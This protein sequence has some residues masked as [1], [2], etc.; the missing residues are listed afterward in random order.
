[1]KNL[2]AIEGADGAGKSTQVTLL[3]T[4]LIRRGYTV[5]TIKFPNYETPT[6]KL[7]SSYLNG[8]L[9]EVSSMNPKLSGALYAFD[10][11]ANLDMLEEAL[12][13]YDYVILDR[14]YYSNV[15][16][17]AI[18]GF[19]VDDLLPHTLSIES[20]M[21]KAV[22][23]VLSLPENYV[24]CLE[25]RDAADSIAKDGGLDGIEA[26]TERLRIVT[27]NW[28]ELVKKASL[29]EVPV[30]NQHKSKL[31]PIDVHEKVMNIV[32]ETTKVYLK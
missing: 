2:I 20:K 13:T 10:R 8:E 3:A 31:S 22:T 6:G 24:S 19:S 11:L 21:P 16:T 25:G 5:K 29:F 1:M 17:Q 27:N 4:E 12:G 14:Y 26:D 32:E 18:N 9:G 15:A 7:V 28:R 30:I 23:I